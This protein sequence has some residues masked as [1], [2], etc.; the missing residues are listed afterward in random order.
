MRRFVKLFINEKIKMYSKLGPWIMM[1][2][3]IAFLGL[4]V[5][6][7]ASDKEDYGDNWKR[8]LE[9]ET[10]LLEEEAAQYEDMYADIFRDEIA[11]NKYRIENDIPPNTDY[12]VWGF[13]I[14]AISNISFI[15]LFTI[16][17]GAGI[18]SSEF[19]G[20]T[21]KLLLIRP[22]K[23]WK[24]LLSKYVAVISYAIELLIVL[25]VISFIL[26]IIFLDKQ[27]AMTP[28]LYVK[29]GIVYEKN[30]LLYILGEY[31]Y[32]CVDLIMMVTFAFMMSTVFR[33]NAMAIGLSIFLMFM[34]TTICA[35]L[36]KYEWVKYILFANLNIKQY[37]SI[38]TPPVEGMT[39]TFSVIIL[40]VYFIVFNVISWLA[41]CKR[42]ASV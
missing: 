39:L 8:T 32:A 12:S 22:Y 31:G 14:D 40:I 21:I 23:R 17:V 7:T 1:L 19:V 29:D 24:I 4:G 35:A 6:L 36:S 37:Y 15:T 28:Y 30:I 42:D 41:F 38:G 10:K 33:S 3:L 5:Y 16:I 18:V 25:F 20:G 34:G 9:Y 13:M 27:G 26:G 11:I 2:I